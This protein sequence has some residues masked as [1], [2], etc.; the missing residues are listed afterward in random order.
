MLRL[1]YYFHDYLLIS[2]TIGLNIFIP[3][4]CNE[5]LCVNKYTETSH[6]FLKSLLMIRGY[7]S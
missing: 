1:H 6:K 2:L 4:E 5:N 7:E 3:S